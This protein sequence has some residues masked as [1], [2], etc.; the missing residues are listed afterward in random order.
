[1]NFRADESLGKLLLSYTVCIAIMNIIRDRYAAWRHSD[2]SVME[3]NKN[4]LISLCQ[5]AAA[6]NLSFEVQKAEML[7]HK[8]WVKPLSGSPCFER[9][10]TGPA[11]C[12]VAAREGSWTAQCTLQTPLA[13]SEAVQ[14]QNTPFGTDSSHLIF[15][16]TCI[17]ST[18]HAEQAGTPL[19]HNSPKTFLMPRWEWG[20]KV[21]VPLTTQTDWH[22]HWSQ[23]PV[24]IN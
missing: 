11:P 12:G 21:P 8:P 2:H 1:M 20:E 7:W 23:H 14:T 4:P 17:W 22:N 10:P 9:P 6:V 18:S 24:Q 19:G 16:I 3:E 13:P 15:A 5:G